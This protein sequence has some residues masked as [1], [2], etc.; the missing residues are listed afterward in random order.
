MRVFISYRRSDNRD[1]AARLADRLEETPGIREVFIDI[2]DIAPGENFATRI[3]AALRQSDVCLIL[4]GDDWIGRRAN[5]AM[6]RMFDHDDFVRYEVGAALS[7]GKRVIPVL[8][9]NAGMPPREALPP[10]LQMIVLKNAV[11]VRHASFRQ[12][13]EL[14]G[15]AI[16]ERGPR[17]AFARWRRRHPFWD[18]LLSAAGGALLA[19]A[20]LIG[21]AALH[22]QLTGGK[23]LEDTL[24]SRGMVWLVIGLTLVLGAAVPLL[25]RRRRRSRG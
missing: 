14:L 5:G 9:N 13:M 15:D 3:D 19:A 11:F 8:L 7:S 1:M 23:A 4:I 24:G 2:E 22:G 10:D 18:G 20:S 25:S 12:D 16:F 17:G 21:L 6:A